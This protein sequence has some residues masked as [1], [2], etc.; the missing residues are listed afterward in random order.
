MA[1][2]TGFVIVVWRSNYR[3]L[4]WGVAPDAKLPADRL[5]RLRLAQWSDDEDEE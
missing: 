4:L 1:G 2:F 3:P 5:V